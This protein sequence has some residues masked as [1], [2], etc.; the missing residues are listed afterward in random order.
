[1]RRIRRKRSNP[2]KLAVL[3]ALAL[4][5]CGALATLAVADEPRPAAAGAALD[6]SDFDDILM[7]SMEDTVKALEPRIGAKDVA[8]ATEDAEFLREGLQWAESYFVSK[9]VADAAA[10]AKEGQEHAANVVKAL[11]ANDFDAAAAA[12]R[13]VSKTCRSCHDAYRP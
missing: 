6:F 4:A 1:L 5:A 11:A 7:Q 13:N 8:A 10:L 2:F 9:G 12:A 3:P